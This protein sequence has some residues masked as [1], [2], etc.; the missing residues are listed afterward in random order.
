[1]IDKDVIDKDDADAV[2]RDLYQECVTSVSYRYP[3]DSFD[4]LPG[5]IQKLPVADYTYVEP[6]E[7]LDLTDQHYRAAARCYRY[8]S[9]EHPGWEA[10]ASH[11]AVEHL[12]ARSG[13][14]QD[15]SDVVWADEPGQPDPIPW[16]FGDD[17]VHP[18]GRRA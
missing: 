7:K 11:D 9:C 8:Q 4:E 12:I 10:S 17:L 13:G 2:G 3:D 6:S 15:D 18:D 1:M 14:E 16:G 5:L